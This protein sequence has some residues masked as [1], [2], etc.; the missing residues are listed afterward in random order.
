MQQDQVKG[1][2]ERTATV[3]A[4]MLLAW[5]V[6][7]G[8]IGE[9]DVATL[10]PAIILIPSLLYGWWINRP[11]ALVQSVAALPGTVV[12]TDEKIAKSTPETNVVSNTEAKV[13]TEGEVETNPS[14]VVT[15]TKTT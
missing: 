8:W 10:L 12:I 1:I 9:S 7:K 3:V 14:V 15:P 6:R 5:L 13:V 4:T 11:K 2:I